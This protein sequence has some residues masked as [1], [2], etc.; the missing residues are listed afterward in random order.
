MYTPTVIFYPEP[1]AVSNCKRLQV[2]LLAHERRRDVVFAPFLAVAGFRRP[3]AG[4]AAP[5]RGTP[6]ITNAC[7]TA[8]N[9]TSNSQNPG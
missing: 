9:N 2:R 4:S 7:P 1:I 6:G 5:L 3:H 8:P